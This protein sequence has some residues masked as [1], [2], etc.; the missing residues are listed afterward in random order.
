MQ[1]VK[2]FKDRMIKVLN[3]VVEIEVDTMIKGLDSMEAYRFSQ[4][5]AMSS[6]I[7]IERIEDEYKKL[8][9]EMYNAEDDST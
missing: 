8:Y 1:N 4:A 7:M 2:T 3:E 9:K 5:T 6:K